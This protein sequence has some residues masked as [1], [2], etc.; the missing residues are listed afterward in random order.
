MTDWAHEI[1][2]S[3]REIRKNPPLIHN[4]T[5]F[6]V[7]NSSA[8]AI[9]ALGASPVMAHAPEEV[10]EMAGH[11]RAIVLNIG[12]LESAWIES[13]LLAGKAANRRNIPVILD[14]V[15]VGATTYRTTTAHRILNEVHCSIIR[16]NAAE[17]LALAG[18]TSTIRG[19]DSLLDT[20]YLI[21]HARAISTT[22][23]AVIAV[24]GVE[25]I[26]SDGTRCLG[27]RGGDAMFRHVTG[28]GCAASAIVACFAAVQ[29]DYVHAAA[30]ALAYYGIAGMEAARLAKGPG[31]FQVELFD[32]L[33]NI[34]LPIVQQTVNIRK[35]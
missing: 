20:D 32:A 2:Q 16:G 1:F 8:N 13:M 29:N 15:G 17:I 4:L 18:H 7:M 5:N 33:Q 21:D 27:V 19:V 34:Q 23:N 14:P 11:A 6:V 28:T 25:D 9:L 30:Q 31:S 10:E 3:L 35:L 12:T 22:L 26:V 24:T